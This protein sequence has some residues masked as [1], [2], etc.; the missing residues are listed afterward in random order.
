MRSIPRIAAALLLT[1]VLCGCSLMDFDG[2]ASGQEGLGG[3]GGL[4]LDNGGGGTSGDADAGMA[5]S[6]AGTAGSGPV[7]P[8]NL[9]ANPG[10]EEIPSRWI[11][12]GG[13]NLALSSDSPHTGN[14]CLLIS[15]RTENWQGPGYDLTFSLKPNASY[16]ATIWA[17]VADGSQ[18]MQLTYKHRCEDETEDTFVPFSLSTRVSTD[19]TELSASLVVADCKAVQSVIYVEGPAA[20][21]EFYIDDTSVVLEAL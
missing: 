5:G 9:I 17:R 8:T 12:V 2:L 6:S 16:R 7:A 18:P 1:T 19:W 14:S 21:A 10:F 20:D 3:A 4:G 11:A 13:C 15:N